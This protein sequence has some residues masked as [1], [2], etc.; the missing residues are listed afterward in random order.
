MDIND[1]YVEP[2]NRLYTVD[3]AAELFFPGLSRRALRDCI[4]GRR[5][6][7]R[8]KAMKLGRSWVLTKACVLD[9]I[10]QLDQKLIALPMPR[11]TTNNDSRLNS[12]YDSLEKL[13]INLE[14]LGIRKNS[15]SP[16]KQ[17][18]EP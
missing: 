11:K 15:N 13:G 17:K 12:A 3:E 8:L 18:E 6:G 1:Y 4:R 16:N 2:E 14:K 9:F 10:R 7:I 5:P